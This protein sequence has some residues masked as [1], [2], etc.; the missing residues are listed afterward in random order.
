[1]GKKRERVE[2]LK[3]EQD[4]RLRDL[5]VGKKESAE[6]KKGRSLVLCFRKE[7][8]VLNYHCEVTRRPLLMVMFGA[9]RGL[10]LW[11]YCVILFVF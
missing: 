5:F 6:R 10:H 1:M 7:K 4:V 3:E 9:I 11:V 2:R 8:A